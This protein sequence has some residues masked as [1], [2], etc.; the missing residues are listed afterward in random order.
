M[1]IRLLTYPLLFAVLFSCQALRSALAIELIDKDA[2]PLELSVSSTYTDDINPT[3]NNKWAAWGVQLASKGQ[4]VSAWEG[5]ELKLD[6]AADLSRYQLR[7]TNQLMEESQNFNQYKVAVLTRFFISSALQLDAQFQHLDHTQPFGQGISQ[8]REEVFKADRFKQNNASVTLVYGQDISHRY[9][10]L[11]GFSRQTRYQA[12]NPYSQ[13]FNVDQQGVELDVA[14]KKSSASSLLLRLSAIDDNFESVDREDSQVFQ[15][16][17]GMKWQ[18]SGKTSMEALLG[19]FKR[20]LAMD[21]SSSGLSWS[22]DINTQPNERWLF[23]LNSARF[24]GVSKSENTS[25]SVEQNFALA[26]VFKASERWHFSTNLK[27]GR[28]EF[29]EVSRISVLNEARADL[30]LALNINSYN[31]VTLS[32]GRLDQSYDDISFDIQ[33]NEVRL[34]WQ[35]SL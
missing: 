17:I 30:Q 29:D 35:V 20:N 28:T 27:V 11:K 7:E 34:A 4:L 22:L 2:S 1:K 24:S 6:Y 10:A 19:M 16:L 32:L 8:L 5:A 12:I 31:S 3:L 18:P 33:Q 21:E 14:Y 25:N 23:K 15:A 26:A 13:F 9:I